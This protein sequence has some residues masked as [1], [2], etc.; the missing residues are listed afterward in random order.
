MHA[1]LQP[2]IAQLKKWISRGVWKDNRVYVR[3]R[4][5]HGFPPPQQHT[6]FHGYK[7]CQYFGPMQSDMSALF[8]QHSESRSRNSSSSIRHVK[9]EGT[10]LFI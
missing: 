10:I 1:F 8:F 3:A 4:Q 6:L 7:E 5:T 9:L 2:L